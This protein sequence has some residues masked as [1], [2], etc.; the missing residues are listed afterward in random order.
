MCPPF[1]VPGRLP[2]QVF[3]VA[4]FYYVFIW[5][6]F[7]TDTRSLTQLISYICALFRGGSHEEELRRKSWGGG[8]EELR[9]RSW[10]WGGVEEEEN[11]KKWAHELRHPKRITRDEHVSLNIPMK[12][13]EMSSWAETS[14]ENRKI[15]ARELRHP[16]EISRDEHMNWDIPRKPQEMSTW[17]ETSQGIHKKSARELRHPKE[18]TRNEHVS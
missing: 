16:N 5:K 3:V 14:Q 7:I 18:R 10:E 13:Q 15:W 6:T 4:C 2:A 17:A 9:R 12:F 8:A 1:I 11:R